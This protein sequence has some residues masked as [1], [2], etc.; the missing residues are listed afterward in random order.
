MRLEQAVV[1]DPELGYV[2]WIAA[3]LVASP[4]PAGQQWPK[5]KHA[6]GQYELLL[7]IGCGGPDLGCLEVQVPAMALMALTAH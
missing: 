3:S 2:L 6:A 5:L 4:V 7:D 1:G